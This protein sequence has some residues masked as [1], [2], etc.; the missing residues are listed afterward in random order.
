M[1]RWKDTSF[2]LVKIIE[3]TRKTLHKTLREFEKNISVKSSTFMT[4][5]KT[6]QVKKESIVEKISDVICKTLV[7]EEPISIFTVTSSNGR[8]V[9]N[10]KD[11]QIKADKLT[12]KA[13]NKLE[14]PTLAEDLSEMLPTV[15]TEMEKLQG[16]SVDL[17]KTKEEQKA[18]AGFIQQ[19]KRRGLNDLFKSLQSMGLS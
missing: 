12:K 6:D 17:K 19:G 7:F 13:I 1:A 11:L 5:M 8:I 9:R 15:T 10:F 3:K 4:E 16:L 14:K 2:W 18:Q